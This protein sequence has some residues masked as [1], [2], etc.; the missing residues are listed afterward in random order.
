MAARQHPKHPP[1]PPNPPHGPS[2]LPLHLGLAG[3]IWLNWP[4]LWQALQPGWS[5]SKRWW[6][7]ALQARAQSLQA[8]AATLPP[9]VLQA[10][11]AAEGLR[12][13]RTYLAG[14]A[15]Y[16]RAAAAPTPTR[17][18]PCVLA[19]S[20]LGQTRCLDYAPHLPTAPRLLVVP[21]LINR[22]TLFDLHGGWS[23]LRWLVTQGIRPLLLDWGEAGAPNL[24]MTV[25]VAR[26][27]RVLAALTAAPDQPSLQLLGHCLGGTMAVAAAQT[28]TEQHPA[29]LRSLILLS[30]PW[31]FH[32]AQSCSNQSC[33]NQSGSHQFSSERAGRAQSGRELAALWQAL[34]PLLPA[35][36]LVPASL[37][38]SLFALLQP[39]GVVD[40]FRR[41]AV[42]P[43]QAAQLPR[44]AQVE[45][46]L[47][48]GVALPRAVLQTIIQEWYGANAPH[49]GTWR[50][51][52]RAV[53]P[54]GLALPI[55]LGMPERDHIVPPA[56]AAALAQHCP[57]ATRLTVPLGHIG[58]IVSRRA[59]ALVWRQ[60][61]A[62]VKTH[63]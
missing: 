49:N 15:V 53:Q 9:E 48:D 8:A 52:G 25:Y 39:A 23:L 55:L 2:P 16:R 21:S 45:A 37:T 63:G 11:L 51:D 7:P 12:R 59:K 50:V 1:A 58:L 6:Q 38:Q 61:A 57:H 14:I 5:G 43:D 60:L 22:A 32:A 40:K 62:W 10:A 35:T 20:G 33:S 31:D 47:N 30:T 19:I 18:P 44:F 26:L 29:A 46:W 54:Q 28:L 27:Q 3:L 13:Y 42:A 24:T 56:S 34:S 4:L 17:P 41:L 36:G